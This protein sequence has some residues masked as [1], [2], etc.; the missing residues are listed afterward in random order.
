MSRA[1]W[2]LEGDGAALRSVEVME[3]WLWGGGG[4]WQQET[5]E[6]R[7]SGRVVFPGH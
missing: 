1:C 7:K 6:V 2:E 4:K 3:C 5:L